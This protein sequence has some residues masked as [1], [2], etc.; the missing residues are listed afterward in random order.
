VQGGQDYF[1]FV[2]GTCI[3]ALCFFLSLSL[4]FYPLQPSS[5]HHFRSCSLTASDQYP[6]A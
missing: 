3:I 5:E 4:Y 6:S 2:E 1:R